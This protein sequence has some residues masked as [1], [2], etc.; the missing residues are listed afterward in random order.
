MRTALL[1]ALVA[2]AGTAAAAPSGLVT[3]PTADVVPERQWLAQVQNGNTELSGSGSLF[4]QP[5]PALQAQLGFLHGRLEA[6]CDLVAVD[7]PRDYRPVANA[8]VLLVAEGYALPAV[9][10]GI[11]QLGPRLAGYGYVVASRTLNY[12]RLQYQKFRAHHRNL[13]LRGIRLHAGALGTPKDP[14]ALLGSDV[15]LSDHAVLQADWIS[16]TDHALT[17][18]GAWIA[19]PLLSAQ[20]ALLVQNGG[21]RIDGVQLGVTRQ[22]PW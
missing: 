16:G 10:A 14:H 17:L 22:L 13:K 1:A 12:E 7:G 18:G 6:G 11:A 2:L 4:E 19:S 5:E 15:E 9:A 20:A 8:K 3:I 21:D